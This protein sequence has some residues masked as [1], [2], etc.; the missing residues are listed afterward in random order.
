MP[1]SVAA[2]STCTR[3]MIS[4]LSWAT[5]C[6]VPAGRRERRDRRRDEEQGD[7]PVAR[8]PW[9]P[10]SVVAS[11]LLLRALRRS[12]SPND[13]VRLG[14]RHPKGRARATRWRGHAPLHGVSLEPCRYDRCARVVA[15]SLQGRIPSRR[16]DVSQPRGRPWLLGTSDWRP[17]RGRD[18][19]G[20]ATWPD[21]ALLGIELVR[22][23]QE[24]P[25][26]NPNHVGWGAAGRAASMTE[27]VWVCADRDVLDGG[28]R[29]GHRK[30]HAIPERAIT[31]CRSA[32][33]AGRRSAGRPRTATPA[34][35]AGRRRS[36]RGTG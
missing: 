4:M 22:P 5:A 30:P 26:R 10:T 23:H 29:R 8:E 33:A 16:R 20:R 27:G 12:Q 19:R 36:A 6:R 28:S 31:A 35:P 1:R 11:C 21:Q 17:S 14:G 2:C 3:V 34:W 25:A 15:A 18:G 7:H 32:P 24:R 13:P 9:N